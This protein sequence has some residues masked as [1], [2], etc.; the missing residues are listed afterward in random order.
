MFGRDRNAHRVLAWKTEG[1]GL[2]KL[3]RRWD[4]NIK[5]NVKEAGLEDMDWTY[6]R[7]SDELL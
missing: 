5:I 4:D 2:V 6:L 3:R 7:T 1:N